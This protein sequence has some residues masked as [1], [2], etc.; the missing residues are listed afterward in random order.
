MTDSV[1]TKVLVYDPN[2]EER[3]PLRD[4]LEAQHLQG[5]R[6]DELSRFLRFLESK[7]DLGGLFIGA[8]RGEEEVL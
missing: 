5:L 3:Q 4:A 1:S 2:V 7:I 8:A 6:V